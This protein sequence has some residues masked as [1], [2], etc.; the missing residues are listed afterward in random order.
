M[1]HLAWILH[2]IETVVLVLASEEGISERNRPWEIFSWHVHLAW[3]LVS[4][5]HV[6]SQI[7]G[8]TN[9][10]CR[11]WVFYFFLFGWKWTS[12]CG[13]FI[14]LNRTHIFFDSRPNLSVKLSSFSRDARVIAPSVSGSSHSPSPRNAQTLRPRVSRRPRSLRYS[15]NRAW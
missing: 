3:Q 14:F 2:S 15:L 5:S 8:V 11:F 7:E 9:F 12:C 4:V 1:M 6:S 10:Q 13:N